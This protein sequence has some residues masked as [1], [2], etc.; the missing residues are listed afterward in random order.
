[1]DG[2]DGGQD[3]REAARIPHNGNLS[4]GRMFELVDFDGNP[5]SKDYAERRARYEVLQEIIQTKGS[6]ETHPTLS[7]NDEFAGDLGIAGWEYGNLTLEGEPE[8][9]QMRPTM[10]LRA[11]LLRGMEL[12]QKL[13]VNPF[14]FGFV[15]RTDY[16]AAGYA[17][18]WATDNTRAALWDALKRRETYATSGSRM[19]LRFFGGWG[20][21]KDDA[22]RRDRSTR[23]TS[24]AQSSSAAGATPSSTRRPT[25]STRRACSRS[26]PRAGRPSRLS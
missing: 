19:T 18:V 2:E 10:Y 6:S 3:G 7:P 9:P 11:G 17:A 15:S 8:S 26:P 14:K 1:V 13:G 22:R 20:F 21:T 25:R 24:A 23:T 16:M 5:L 12:E 4:N